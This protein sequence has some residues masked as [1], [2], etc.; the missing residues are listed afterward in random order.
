M[1]RLLL[2]RQSGNGRRENNGSR[3][4]VGV[5]LG[6]VSIFRAG[7]DREQVLAALLQI[8]PGVRLARLNSSTNSALSPEVVSR[9]ESPAS[10]HTELE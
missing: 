8:S 7:Q 2:P 1:L 5:G 6:R 4:R 10:S 3:S 9:I